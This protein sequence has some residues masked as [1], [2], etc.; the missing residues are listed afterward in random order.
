MWPAAET[1]AAQIVAATNYDPTEDPFRILKRMGLEVGLGRRG[2]QATVFRD[3]VIV[4]PSARPVRQRFDAIHEAVHLVYEAQGE[5]PSER[6]VNATTCATLCPRQP[7]LSAL[8]HYG[9]AP[10]QLAHAF[11]WVSQETLARRIVSLRPAVLWVCDVRPRRR[12]YRVISPEWQWPVRRPLPVEAE[13][14]DAALEDRCAVEPIGGVR[15]WPV[16]DGEWVRVL[17]LS[18][19]EALLPS[20]S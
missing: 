12:L 15:A 14:M 6:L 11:P 20:L 5:D 17:C 18:D 8:R 1:V 7:F 13:A 16:V 19:A 4:D 10:D 2:C 9:W 3:E